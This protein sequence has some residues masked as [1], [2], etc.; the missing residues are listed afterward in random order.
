M[1]F[2]K[3]HGGKE[4]VFQGFKKTVSCKSMFRATVLPSCSQC[5]GRIQP[6]FQFCRGHKGRKGRWDERLA[7]IGE[8]IRNIL[9][10]WTLLQSS[11]QC[12]VSPFPR[13]PLDLGS[14]W[15]IDMSIDLGFATRSQP[16]WLRSELWYCTRFCCLT[17]FLLVLRVP[18][19][20]A[21]WNLSSMGTWLVD[22]GW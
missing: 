14:T 15:K 9:S 7:P 4:R 13:F 8:W 20:A 6:L 11:Y 1:Q 3:C 10:R 18:A 19:L 21:S 12:L 22:I 2:P 17:D 5:G 16:S